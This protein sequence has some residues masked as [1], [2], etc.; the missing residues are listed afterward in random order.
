MANIRIKID[1]GGLQL[2]HPR[3][4]DR[5]GPGTGLVLV[6]RAKIG[7]EIGQ[8]VFLVCEAEVLRPFLDEKIQRIDRRHVRNE[9]DRDGQM[10]GSL[11]EHHA[12][13][14]VAE[15]VLLPVDEMLGRLD[16]QR[17]A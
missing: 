5:S 15:D 11:G 2:L 10:V 16:L 3:G 8:I 12:G 14:K 17:I 6:H 9:S 13:E 7:L 4:H 1:D